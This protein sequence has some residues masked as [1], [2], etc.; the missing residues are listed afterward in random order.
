MENFSLRM[1]IKFFVDYSK[2]YF[3]SERSERKQLKF[4]YS[5]I[6]HQEDCKEWGE[7]MILVLINIISTSSN[8]L[9]ELKRNLAIE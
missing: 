3:K 2:K 9:K 8:D 4:F 1:I 5:N 7:K 6:C